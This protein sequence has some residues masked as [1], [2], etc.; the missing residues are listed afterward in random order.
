MLLNGY[1]LAFWLSFLKFTTDSKDGVHS[2]LK[3]EL[4]E[5]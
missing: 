4:R 3:T 2:S 1:A 5:H